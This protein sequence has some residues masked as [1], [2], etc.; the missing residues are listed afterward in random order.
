MK[1]GILVYS[2]QANLRSRWLPSDIKMLANA[3]KSQ[4]HE[5]KIFRSSKCQLFYANSRMRVLYAGK[6]FPVIDMMIPRPTVLDNAD[7][8]L[9]LNKHLLLMGIPM[10]NGYMPV[11]RA[12]NKIRMLQILTH[13]GIKVP[14]TVVLKRLEY[15]DDAIARVGGFPVIIKTPHGSFGK[16]VAIVESRR[17]LLSS[18]DILWAQSANRNLLIQEYVAE[19]EGRDIRAFVVGNNVIASME[20]QSTEGDFRSNINN[21]GTGVSMELT[22]EEI[23]LSLKATEALNLDISGVDILRTK[24][25]PVVME[26]NANP[27]LEG[28]TEVTGIDVAGAIIDFAVS[29]VKAAADHKALY[30][31]EEPEEVSMQ[32]EPNAVI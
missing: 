25:G 18:L 17:S 21:G 26:I 12:K 8:E 30:P 22:A 1:I 15:M 2:S 32:D 7:L 29:K 9:T 10:L 6:K 20:R 23:T 4:G 16:G 31:D 3:A 27:G 5:V 14:K 19:S 11:L 24:N 28:I 13:K